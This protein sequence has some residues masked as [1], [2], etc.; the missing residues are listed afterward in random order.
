MADGSDTGRLGYRHRAIMGIAGTAT[1]LIVLITLVGLAQ[2]NVNAQ[3]GA[4]ARD[5]GSSINPV[6]TQYPAV[7][8]TAAVVP[9]VQ[10]GFELAA[11]NTTQFMVA[12]PTCV[13]GG[14]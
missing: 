2:A 9:V 4:Q 7:P 10:E 14:C 11:L 8:Q 5:K 13:P 12:V 3:P 6:A 1:L